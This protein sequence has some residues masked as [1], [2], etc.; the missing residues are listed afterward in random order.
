[1]SSKGKNKEE[2]ID[3]DENIVILNWE[4]SNLN[5]DQMHIV[6]E[7]LQKKAKQKRLRE[8]R[9]RE[10]QVLEDAKN[11]LAEALGTEVDTSQPILTQLVEVIQKFNEDLNGQEK[12]L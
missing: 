5:L 8:E 7:L 3:L 9:N 4:I 10:F 2:D 6:G 12:L 1:M 11:I